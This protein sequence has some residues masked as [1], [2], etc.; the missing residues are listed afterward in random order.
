M[1][2]SRTS[3]DQGRFR[4]TLGHFATGVAIATTRD[5]QGVPWGVTI[6]SFAS[7]SL[8]PPLVLFCLDLSAQSRPAFTESGC[9]AVAVLNEEQSALSGGFALSPRD[10]WEGVPYQTGASGAPILTG[11]LA[12]L[13]CATEAIH[14]GGDHV[15]L[16]GR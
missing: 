16:V 13:D 11:A 3:I 10:P 1:S 9:F 5:L 7:V 14:P 8:H 6:N 12:W 2:S 15:I 4:A